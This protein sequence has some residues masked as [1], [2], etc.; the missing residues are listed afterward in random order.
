MA[1]P[2]R[3]GDDR[4][5]RG[6]KARSAQERWQDNMDDIG[7]AWIRRSDAHEER[8]RLSAVL[9]GWWK[10]ARPFKAWGLYRT[11]TTLPSRPPCQS[12]SWGRDRTPQERRGPER[13]CDTAEWARA[14]R[15]S[16]GT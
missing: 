1:R 3:L 12:D 16:A 10:L 15:Q 13:P 11:H 4:G 7:R 14:W 6:D 2:S 9:K 8:K 5:R